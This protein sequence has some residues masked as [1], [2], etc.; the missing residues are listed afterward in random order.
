MTSRSIPIPR[1]AAGGRPLLVCVHQLGEGVAELS[2]RHD[3]LEALHQ[4]RP[5]AVV[6]GKGRHFFRV[7]A[8]EHGPPQLGLG[9]LLVDLEEQLPRPPRGR[10]GDAVVGSDRG[11][12]RHRR[13]DVDGHADVLLDELAQAGAPPRRGQVEG[14]ASVGERGGA[15]QLAGQARHQLLDEHHHVVV[16]GIGLVELEHRELGVVAA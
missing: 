12:L 4:P 2:A 13:I 10:Y 1:P 7:V 15:P 16:V 5:A 11:Q 3:R 14:A 6:A 8:D 9:R